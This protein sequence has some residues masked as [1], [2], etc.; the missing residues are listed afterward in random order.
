MSYKQL[1]SSLFPLE[2]EKKNNKTTRTTPTLLC[3][4]T[5]LLQQDDFCA[6]LLRTVT[7]PP[8]MPSRWGACSA[9][10]YC[11]SFLLHL[12]CHLVASE[13]GN[14]LLNMILDSLLLPVVRYFSSLLM[15]K[16]VEAQHCHTWLS[17][18]MNL[19][20]CRWLS[21][22]RYHKMCQHCCKCPQNSPSQVSP[23]TS[24][25]KFLLLIALWYSHKKLPPLWALL[26]ALPCLPTTLKAVPSA[27]HHT[28]PSHHCNQIPGKEFTGLFTLKHSVMAGT[29]YKIHRLVKI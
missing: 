16:Q 23:L 17:W 2:G 1:I 7:V 12:I 3:Q 28:P 5:E 20:T 19:L 21:A 9:C 8:A 25:S 14:S 10:S 26:M 6:I 11:A 24:H 15:E 29:C 13:E 22:V 4:D 18:C 27:A